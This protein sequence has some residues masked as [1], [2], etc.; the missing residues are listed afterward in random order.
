MQMSF[1]ADE[2]GNFKNNSVFWFFFELSQN[3]AALN[4]AKPSR[5]ESCEAVEVVV[6]RRSKGVVWCVSY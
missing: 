5:K 2:F 4:W 6:D 3:K 1:P